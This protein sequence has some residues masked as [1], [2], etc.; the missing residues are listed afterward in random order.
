[1]K[2]FSVFSKLGVSAYLRSNFNW[3]FVRRILCFPEENVYLGFQ[4]QTE[5][6]QGYFSTKIHRGRSNGTADVNLF[7]KVPTSRNGIQDL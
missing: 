2:D 4:M 5:V 3:S 6:N 7:L 1:M